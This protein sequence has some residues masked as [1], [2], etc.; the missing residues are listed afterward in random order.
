MCSLLQSLVPV[1]QRLLENGAVHSSFYRFYLQWKQAGGEGHAL[2]LG[3]CQATLLRLNSWYSA[4]KQYLGAPA[5]YN[6]HHPLRHVFF[7]GMC[8]QTFLSCHVIRYMVSHLPCWCDSL[9]ACGRRSAAGPRQRPAGSPPLRVPLG[10]V[11]ALSGGSAAAELTEPPL[12]PVADVNVQE[13]LK[14]P[15]CVVHTHTHTHVPF[16]CA[17]SIPGP[18]AASVDGP[19]E[20]LAWCSFSGTA[21]PPAALLEAAN[22]K[23]RLRTCQRVASL[24][25]VNTNRLKLEKNPVSNPEHRELSKRKEIGDPKF[26]GFEMNDWKDLDCP[27][28]SETCPSVRRLPRGRPLLIRSGKVP[29][30]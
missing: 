2:R 7:T 4:R 30:T 17:G 28:V 11:L 13:Q 15:C 10:S 22:D 23:P 9:L 3:T 8:K 16:P 20:L 12:W 14:K 6:I 26:S 29:S 19:P 5:V 24:L 25:N 27:T 1:I 18:P 21:P